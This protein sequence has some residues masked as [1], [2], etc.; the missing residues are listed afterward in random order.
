LENSKGVEEAV[1][2]KVKFFASLREIAGR[3]EADV[4]LPKGS[5]VGSLLD[6]LSRRYGPKFVEHI[7]ERGKIKSHIIVMLDARSIH[8]LDGP[9]TVLSENATVAILPSFF[10]GG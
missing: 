3:R 5:T 4:K 1:K 8:L 7:F 2:V 6:E 10:A 9:K